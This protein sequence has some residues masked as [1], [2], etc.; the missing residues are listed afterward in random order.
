MEE[1]SE[2]LKQF[3]QQ[4]E[5]YVY[6][7]IALCVTGIGFSVVKTTGLPL[8]WTQIPLASAVLSWGL[9][10]HCGLKFMRYT[11]STLYANKT[12][13]DILQGK[14]PKAGNHPQ[15]IQAAAEGVIQ[16]MEFNS[17]RAM[18]LS[19][20]QNRLFYFGIILFIA[21]HVI[22]MYYTT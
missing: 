15:L 6:Y 18:K 22:E 9:S 3:R 21:W 10:I 1:Q 11:I 12:Y 4:Q 17:D 16:A 19:Q 13:L 14:H 5:K 8:K 7:I 2:L 20:W